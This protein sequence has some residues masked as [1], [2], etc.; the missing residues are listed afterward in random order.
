MNRFQ[1]L[2]NSPF[3]HNATPDNTKKALLE[4]DSNP[5]PHRSSA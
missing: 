5:Q 3:Y 2:Q 1:M 4:L